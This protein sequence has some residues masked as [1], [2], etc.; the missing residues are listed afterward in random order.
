MGAGQS[1][2]AI[3]GNESEVGS[4]VG[5]EVDPP[6]VLDPSTP[7]T[8]QDFLHRGREVVIPDVPGRNTA[9]D[10]EGFD[11]A[12]QKRFLALG[13]VDPVNGFTRMGKP[14]SKHI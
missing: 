2:F 9:N 3:E 14:E 11:M 10:I 8:M 6:L 1:W 12:F 4:E 5:S 7:G 13:R